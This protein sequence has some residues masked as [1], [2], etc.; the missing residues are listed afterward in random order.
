M[1][2]V[3]GGKETDIRF[4]I[5]AEIMTDAGVKKGVWNGTMT[6][7]YNSQ[8]YKSGTLTNITRIWSNGSFGF[9]IMGKIEVDR[10]I[11]QLSAEFLG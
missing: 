4:S 6:G 1:T 9:P 5:K 11:F 10:P 8:L 3:K 2:R 7:T